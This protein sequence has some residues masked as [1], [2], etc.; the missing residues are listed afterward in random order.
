MAQR[1]A[2]VGTGLIGASVGLAAKRA[3]DGAWRASIPTRRCSRRRRAR[4]GRR[5]GGYARG[6]ARRGRAR[7]RRGAG[8]AARRR[9][10]R[11]VLAASAARRAPSRTSARRRTRVCAPAAGSPRFV[12]GH[13]VCGSEARGAGGRA[14]RPLRGRDL[15]PDAA[16]ARPSP[17]ATGSCTGSSPSLGAT[18]VA[19]DPRR[20]R[21]ARRA[22]EPPAAR[23]RERAR[24]P[25]RLDPGRRPRAAAPP[26]EARSGT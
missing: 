8:R 13:P 10:S 14:R 1:L 9:R 21:P 5:R 6:G 17:S 18:P 20:A 25:G 11:R 24:Q 15:V 26:R 4:R 7:G 2:V 22:D 3:G 19:V 12:G 16:A 23:A